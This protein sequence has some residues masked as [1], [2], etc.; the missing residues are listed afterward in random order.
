MH[1]LFTVLT[2]GIPML[3]TTES[4]SVLTS[5]AAGLVAFF[6]PCI[7]PVVPLYMAYL[8]GGTKHVDENGKVSFDRRKTM[9]NT[10]FFVL[11]ISMAYV[12]LALISTSFG[13]FLGRHSRLFGR[14][15]GILIIAL[16]VVQLYVNLKGRALGQE[17]R[18]E[19]KWDRFGM[20]PLVALVL[21]LTFSFAW[22]PCVGPILLS[23]ISMTANASTQALGITYML[24]YTLGFTLPFIALGLFTQVILEFLQKRRNIMRYTVI[25]GAVLMIIM[26]LLMLTGTI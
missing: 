20:N 7:F 12:L 23:V 17:K 21:G 18:F 24:I 11:G 13:S 9:V 19:F 4:A 14:I 2:Q 26:G 6:S 25:A 5:F 1:T 10:L 8:S 22:T 15:G 16:G 3:S